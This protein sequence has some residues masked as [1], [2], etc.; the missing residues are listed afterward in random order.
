MKYN[1]NP[2]LSYVDLTL[3]LNQQGCML[4]GN[5]LKIRNL[6]TL[7]QRQYVALEMDYFSLNCTNVFLVRHL[8][9]FCSD[10]FLGKLEA[11]V[12]GGRVAQRPSGGA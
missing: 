9:F 12:G 6:I 4:L 8:V 10:T 5:R 11:F 1:N 2:P 3:M 7:C